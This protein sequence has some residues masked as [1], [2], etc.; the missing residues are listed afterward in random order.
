MQ[1]SII[2]AIG[3]S[4]SL[5]S[6]VVIG[7]PQKPGESISEPD[8]KAA[9][10]LIEKDNQ[11]RAQYSEKI[12]DNLNQ[13]GEVLGIQEL[14]INKMYF[15]QATKGNYFVTGDGR[16][17]FQGKLQDV[18]HRKHINHIDDAR[19]TIRT[20]LKNMNFDPAEQLPA[21]RVGNPDIPRQGLV[22]VDPTSE[23]TQQFLKQVIAEKEKYH[24]VVALL[25]LVG[26]EAAMDRAKRLYC[27]KDKELALIDLANYTN[28]STGDL[29]EGCNADKILFA[30]AM[31]Q[32]FRIEALPHFVREDGLTSTGLPNDLDEWLATP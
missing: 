13:M 4:V 32:V 7:A 30:A 12:K 27:A 26:G 29:R 2:A 28:E 16:F 22:F 23:I 10:D 5:Y 1:K 25:P 6:A 17:V 21:W 15:V 24:F 8:I 11:S 3:I 19:A 20:P 18:W 31:T 14:P 9:T